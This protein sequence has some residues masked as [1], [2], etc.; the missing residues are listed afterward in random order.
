MRLLGK[1]PVPSKLRVLEL[2]GH[3]A[4]ACL[5]LRSS[6]LPALH[7]LAVCDTRS[8][9]ITVSHVNSAPLPTVHTL[10]LCGHASVQNIF[11]RLEHAVQ[12]N[13]IL[14]AG[15]H[16]VYFLH[17]LIFKLSS[18]PNVQQLHIHNCT[19]DM[20]LM[21]QTFRQSK[22]TFVLLDGCAFLGKPPPPHPNVRFCGAC[23]ACASDKPL[24]ASPLCDTC[25][26][27]S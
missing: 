11:G 18:A 14:I 21:P 23:M 4:G 22:D 17:C 8:D 1:R 19:M 26:Q 13:N 25:D 2:Q 16:E 27:R 7:V 10:C 5:W 24:S 15:F 9:A 12:A 6:S 20:S 3:G